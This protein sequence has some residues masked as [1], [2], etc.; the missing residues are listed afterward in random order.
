M[1][2][3][4]KKRIKRRNK[5][6]F[7]E[8]M[9]GG[10]FMDSYDLFPTVEADDADSR[11]EVQGRMAKQGLILLGLLLLQIGLFVALIYSTINL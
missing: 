9:P 11:N 8:A 3:K 1:E 10:A 2:S 4:R 5:P 6:D 7:Y